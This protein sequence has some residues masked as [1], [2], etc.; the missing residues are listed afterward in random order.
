[1]RQDPMGRQLGQRTATVEKRFALHTKADQALQK[2]ELDLLL[3]GTAK[4]GSGEYGKVARCQGL[5]FGSCLV[6][7]TE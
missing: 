1:M 5:L 7:N 6:S 3:R 4:A 2:K